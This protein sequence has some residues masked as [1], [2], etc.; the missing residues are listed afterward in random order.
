MCSSDLRGFI[1]RIRDLLRGGTD[2]ATWEEVEETLIAAD[3]GADLTIE[4]VARARA[5]RDLPPDLALQTEL[6]DLFATREPVPWPRKPGPGV[7][8]VI[9]VVGVNGTGKTTTI[10]KLA[11]R[12][13]TRGARVLLAAGDTFQIGR[14][15]V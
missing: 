1:G 10:A 13:H 3:L 6:I 11:W 12:F 5:R 14:A 7:P 9:L 8:A 2:D 4:V 15:H